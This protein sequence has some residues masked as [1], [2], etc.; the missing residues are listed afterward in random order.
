MPNQWQR[1]AFIPELNI[2]TKRQ[3]Q[4][5]RLAGFDSELVRR[6]LWRGNS[7]PFDDG[8]QLLWSGNFVLLAELVAEL[9]TRGGKDIASTAN[10]LSA[11]SNQ[12]RKR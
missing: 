3:P 8:Q 4:S 5:K 7:N 10:S 2:Q 1:N 6:N 9:V 11:I 12:A